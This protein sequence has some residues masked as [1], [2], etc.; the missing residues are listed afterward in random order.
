MDKITLIDKEKEFM[1]RFAAPSVLTGYF[2]AAIVDST[3]DE[4]RDAFTLPGPILV[5]NMDDLFEDKTYSNY[6]N[7]REIKETEEEITVILDGG[8]PNG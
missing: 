6:T 2:V 7:I 4:I 8:D 3:A 1:S 5:H